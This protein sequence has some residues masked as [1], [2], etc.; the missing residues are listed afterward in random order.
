MTTGPAGVVFPLVDGRR[1]TSATGRAVLADAV[2]A[3]DAGLAATVDRESD[4]RHGYV[5]AFR[6]MTE[7]TATSSS[8]ASTTAADGLRSVH[9]RFTFDRGG[10]DV[11]LDQAFAAPEG[12]ELATAEVRGGQ[13]GGPQELTLPYRGQ[14]LAGDDLR[15][16][17]DSWVAAGVVEPSHADAVLEV[18]SQPEWLDLR[19]TTVVALGAGAELGPYV[20][21]VRWG[22]HV[23]GVDLP[24][25][26]VWQRLLDRVR[27]SPGRL[28]LPV[29]RPL[30]DDPADEELLATA[31]VDLL[32][33]APALAAWLARLRGPYVLGSYVYAD[34]AEHTRASVAVDALTQALGRVRDDVSLAFLAT[35]TDAF[36][37]P[38]D[39]VEQSRARYQ[40]RGLAT[41]AARRT[42]RVGS[43]GRLFGPNY[44]RLHA[45][46]DGRL[47][48]VHDA[49]VPQQGP[50]YALAK[51][52]Q[53]WRA[54]TAREGGTRVSVNVAPATRTRSVLR[55][56]ALAAAYAGAHRFGIEIFDP[57]T[58]NTLMAA[59][60]VHD[61]RA[62]PSVADPTVPLAHPDELLW[63][64]ANHGGLWRAAYTPRS[65][66]GLAVVLGMLPRGR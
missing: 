66:L 56:R 62:G 21:L 58:S 28:T 22:A 46:E 1:S 60:L 39:A 19:D 54:T 65:V 47:V 33:G 53:R 57:S 48:G 17:L 40:G 50:N 15:R 38:E 34:G 63:H 24:R 49:L 23:V 26:D 9:A 13:V 4:W 36:S 7:A 64:G 6:R 3:V 59:L 14:R 43:A 42:A 27:A 44:R 30:G 61:L 41:R 12:P 55:N 18:A 35:P 5:A 29:R 20:P 45:R 51:R 52:I 11:P 31:G 32:S 37:V 8:A 10:E 16:R 2:R 25:P